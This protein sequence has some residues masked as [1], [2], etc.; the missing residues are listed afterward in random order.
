MI[1]SCSIQFV[2]DYHN[3]IIIINV[4]KSSFLPKVKI[5]HLFSFT[6]STPVLLQITPLL[7]ALIGVVAALI[8]VAIIIVVVIRLRGGGDRDDKG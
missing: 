7:G 2:H 3:V 5:D 4:L 1:I 8:L 6:A